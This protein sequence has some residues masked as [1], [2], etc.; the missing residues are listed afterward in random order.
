MGN[1]WA[2][3][4]AAST[5]IA[6]SAKQVVAVWDSL[7]LFC[8]RVGVSQLDAIKLAPCPPVIVPLTELARCHVVSD[9]DRQTAQGRQENSETAPIT[10]AKDITEISKEYATLLQTIWERE[11][12]EI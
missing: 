12:A 4:E 9:G 5:A 2:G 7:D 10:P 1:T 8:Q 3:E 6:E 11:A